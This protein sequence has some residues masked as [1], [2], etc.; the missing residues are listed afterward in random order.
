[1]QR[2]VMWTPDNGRGF[3]HL[4][5]IES[6][7]KVLGNG[8][9]IGIKNDLPFRVRYEILADAQWRVQSVYVHQETTPGTRDL[10]LLTDGD[11]HWTN[12]AGEHLPELDGCLDV[13]ISET[14]FTNTFSIRRLNLELNQSGEVRVAYLDIPSLT[15][16]AKTHRYTCLDRYKQGA[17]YR[18]EV[19]GEN[20]AARL[21]VDSDSIVSKYPEVFRQVLPE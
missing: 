4:H 21:T 20:Y 18:F 12:H 8:L 3:E 10:W 15:L 13:D 19:V 17:I 5:L 16:S 9:F 14:P 6:K 11:G 1:M 7:S 2:H